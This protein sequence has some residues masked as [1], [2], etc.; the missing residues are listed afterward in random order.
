M[1]YRLFLMDLSE[2]GSRLEDKDW[3]RLLSGFKRHRADAP[4]SLFNYER[5]AVPE[6]GRGKR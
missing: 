2:G 6:G 3:Q 1:G 4:Y 5:R